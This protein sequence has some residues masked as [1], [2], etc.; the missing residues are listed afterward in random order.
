MMIISNCIFIWFHFIAVFKIN[1]TVYSEQTGQSLLTETLQ[2]SDFNDWKGLYYS[3]NFTALTKEGT[4]RIK[5]ELEYGSI[6]IPLVSHAFSIGK[7]I[8]IKKLGWSQWNFLDHMKCGKK[9]H[10]KDP[11]LKGKIKDLRGDPPIFY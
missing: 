10:L 8:F 6:T 1:F 3:G 7:G 2:K 4:F 9:C 11:I 5:A